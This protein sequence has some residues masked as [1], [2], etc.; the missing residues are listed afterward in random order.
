MTLDVAF[1]FDYITKH[2]YK[3]NLQ[4]P[5]LGK[6]PGHA[7]LHLVLWN[8]VP[9]PPNLHQPSL[10]PSRNQLWLQQGLPPCERGT[11]SQRIWVLFRLCLHSPPIPARPKTKMVGKVLWLDFSS[12]YSWLCFVI[13][14]FHYKVL[15]VSTKTCNITVYKADL[16]NA[17]SW[18]VLI[19]LDQ[20]LLRLIVILATRMFA[21]MHTSMLSPSERAVNPARKAEIFFHLN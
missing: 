2:R 18:P 19:S 16:T 1:N 8:N 9:H 3:Q 11:Q 20:Y 14:I 17:V 21:L 15:N 13:G 6:I 4:F 7:H 5:L 12:Q 10:H